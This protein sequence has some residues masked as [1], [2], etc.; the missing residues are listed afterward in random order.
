MLEK[1][2]KETG[3]SKGGRSH[4]RSKSWRKREQEAGIWLGKHAGEDND[5]IFR[6]LKSSLNRVGQYSALG[7]DVTSEKYI[8]EVK[9]RKLPQWLTK[10]WIQAQQ[11]AIWRKKHAV[12]F[13]Y[14]KGV[15][16][17]FTFEGQKYKVPTPLNVIT[18]ERHAELLDKERKLEE[19]E[20]EKLEKENAV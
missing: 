7:Y 6:R 9:E 4:S 16:T 18:Q 3:R 17:E 13:L 5:P 19:L 14:L 15:E 1:P 20:I 8:G 10:A 11:C 2:K 12:L